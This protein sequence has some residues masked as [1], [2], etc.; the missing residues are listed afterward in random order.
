[1]KCHLGDNLY[2][3]NREANHVFFFCKFKLECLN[4]IKVSSYCT[5]GLSCLLYTDAFTTIV[6]GYG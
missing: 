5:S 6:C 4:V 2:P 3:V 1:M